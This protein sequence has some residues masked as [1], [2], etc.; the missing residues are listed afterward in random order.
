MAS[1]TRTFEASEIAETLEKPTN[2]KSRTPR[3]EFSDAANG[4]LGRRA[5]NPRSRKH[6]QNQRIRNL[7]RRARNSRTPQTEISD[8]VQE[9]RDRGNTGKTNESEISDAANGFFGHRKRIFGRRA[10]IFR[11]PWKTKRF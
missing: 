3:T 1:P 2:P 5:G 7:G 11:T 8:A 9:I 10:R 4:N 6:W